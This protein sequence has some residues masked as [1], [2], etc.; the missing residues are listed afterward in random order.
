MK[1]IDFVRNNKNYGKEISDNDLPVEYLEGIYKKIKEEQI[2]TLGE[3]ADGSMT[4]ERW[5]DVMKNTSSFQTRHLQ[6]TKDVKELLIE[7]A[8]QPVLSAM[9]GLWGMIPTG[10]DNGDFDIQDQNGT[11][12][13]ARFGI[14][15]ANE[16]LSGASGLGRHDIFQDLFIN[17]CYMSGLLG[18][19]NMSTEERAF[20]FVDSLERQGAL[21]VAI[22]TAVENG[23]IIGLDGWKYIWGM[24]FELRD[25]QLLSGKNLKE[26]DPDLLTAEFRIEFSRRLMQLDEPDVIKDT[27]RKGLMSLVFGTG[28]SENLSRVVVVG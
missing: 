1:V 13:G 25:L 10:V 14:D 28:S 20:C 7:S 6:D 26:S 24:I 15:L 4:V 12:Q 17:V 19:Y 8:W 11:L 16:I 5:K 27:P 3:G 2:R 18:N 9:S 22:N 21:I 23:D